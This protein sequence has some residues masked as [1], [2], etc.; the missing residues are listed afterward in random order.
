MVLYWFTLLCDAW[1]C[2]GLHRFAL[3][4]FAVL[5][6]G[7][8]CIALLCFAWLCFALFFRFALALRCGFALLRIALLCLALLCV[9]LHCFAVFLIALHC[10]ACIDLPC[11]A[12]LYFALLCF[13]L[14]CVALLVIALYCCASFDIAF[15]CLFQQH[16]HGLCSR[17]LFLDSFPKFV[18]RVFS[19]NPFSPTSPPSPYM[20]TVG[21]IES[22]RAFQ[23]TQ[24]GP[25][26]FG[27]NFS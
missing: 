3:L 16:V 2:F 4:C 20:R 15:R 17:I 11:F 25:I 13:S 1:R 21:K 18:L 10:F 7:V 26:E 6:F 9:T 5:C 23:R 22:D 14:L 12:L 19:K 27:K 8:H 24:V